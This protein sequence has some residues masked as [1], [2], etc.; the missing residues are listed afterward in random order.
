V[1]D[2][3]E[4]KGEACCDGQPE[5]VLIF[6]SRDCCGEITVIEESDSWREGMA[7]RVE[8][9]DENKDDPRVCDEAVDLMLAP[10]KDLLCPEP[11]YESLVDTES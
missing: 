4:L 2:V 11:E 9:S 3:V 7:V 10:S 6:D 1:K 8:F 5:C